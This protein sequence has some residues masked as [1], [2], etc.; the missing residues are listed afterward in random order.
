MTNSMKRSPPWQATQIKTKVD[1][2]LSDVKRFA[3]GREWEELLLVIFAAISF[4]VSQNQAK[5]KEIVLSCRMMKHVTTLIRTATQSDHYVPGAGPR[6]ICKTRAKKTK[7][8]T[9]QSQG[10]FFPKRRIWR[11]WCTWQILLSW[12]EVYIIFK[13]R[14]SQT[15]WRKKVVGF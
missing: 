1:T 6:L 12:H 9:R 15:R 10:P 13:K 11:H 4:A 14:A 7:L 5:A 3:V 8:Q 2:R